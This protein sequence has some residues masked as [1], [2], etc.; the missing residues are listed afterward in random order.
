[1]RGRF[2][3]VIKRAPLRFIFG[4]NR[5]KTAK[6]WLRTPWLSGDRVLP[7]LDLEDETG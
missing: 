7:C 2:A 6:E 4:E 3:T 5:V 1:M